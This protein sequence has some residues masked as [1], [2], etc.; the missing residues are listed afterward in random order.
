MEAP[1]TKELLKAFRW[2]MMDPIIADVTT[3]RAAPGAQPARILFGPFAT[4]SSMKE[5]LC[6]LAALSISKG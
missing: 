1:M 2:G 5:M 3:K 4:I 6:V